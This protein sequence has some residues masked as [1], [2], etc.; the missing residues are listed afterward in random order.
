[1]SSVLRPVMVNLPEP[2][3]EQHEEQTILRSGWSPPSEAQARAA[4]RDRALPMPLGVKPHS[5]KWAVARDRE[6][7]MQSKALMVH[8]SYDII[9]T[10]SDIMANPTVA[11]GQWPVTG[12]ATA[13]PQNKFLVPKKSIVKKATSSPGVLVSKKMPLV[14]PRPPPAHL[15]RPLAPPL[16]P[17]PLQVNLVPKPP[18]HPPPAHLLRPLAPPL[19]PPLQV[20]LVPKPPSHPPPLEVKPVPPSHPPR[21]EVKPVPKPHRRLRRKLK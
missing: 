2:E 10:S 7:P 12:E 15:L 11:S 5:A 1:M 8:P 17:P 4:A 9:A 3:P 14:P 19:Q 21:L 20:N 13:R 16:Q 18:S 6:L